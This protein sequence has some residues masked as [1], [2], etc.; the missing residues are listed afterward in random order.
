MRKQDFKQVEYKGGR[1]NEA[2]V[3]NG[4]WSHVGGMCVVA[5]AAIGI[6]AAV[7]ANG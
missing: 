1:V 2:R 3:G 7:G 5:T 4:N 6:V